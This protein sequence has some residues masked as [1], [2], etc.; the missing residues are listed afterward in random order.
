MVKDLPLVSVVAISFN[1]AEFVLETLDS[2]LKQDYGHI[3][4]IVCDDFSKDGTPALIEQWLTEH[5]ARFHRTLLIASPVNQGVCKNLAL[6]MAEATGEWIKP[7]ACD[8]L[9]C[10]DAISKFVAHAREADC[11]LL[12]SQ[13]TLFHG[14]GASARL[15][16]N[17]LDDARSAQVRGLPAALLQSIRNDNFLPAPSAFYSHALLQRVGGIDTSFKHMDDWPLWLRM[18]PQVSAV[19]WLDK[20]LV[21]Y[22]ISDKSISQKRAAK[23]IGAL[24]YA[25]QQHLHETLQKPFLGGLDR[26]HLGLQAWRKHWVFN[27][28][29]NSWTAY[30]LLMPLQFLSPRT[31]GSV[32][33]RV[34]RLLGQVW[35]NALPL[36]RGL[37]YF[38]PTGLR[39]RVRVFGR[40]ELRIPRSRVVLGRRVVIHAGVALT[41][42]KGGTDTITIGHQSTLEKNSYLNAHGG[43]I[44]V[45]EQVHV[46]VGCVMQGRGGLK[47]G[48]H[49]M[50]GPYAQVYT[51]NHRTSAPSLPRHLL[52]ERPRAV[53]IGDNCWIGANCIVLPGARIDDES[54]VPAG[55][56]VRRI[57]MPSMSAPPSESRP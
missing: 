24:L 23:P 25:D 41:G 19:G 26:W 45:G 33:A 30:R 22:R 20:P 50:F 9:L 31:W 53:S 6:G 4:L 42:N 39:R 2:I 44:V 14:H 40:I 16:G 43:S 27:H 38:G 48:K 28:L 49:T 51:S 35:D 11:E 36:A 12:F 46:G 3:E 15:F 21:L 47:V 5:A 34:S 18:L 57:A 52:G 55:E 54:I 7:I 29:G 13:M 1:Q 10:Q 37:Y 56:I 8:D 17:Y 32:F